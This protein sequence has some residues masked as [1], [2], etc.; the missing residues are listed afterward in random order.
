MRLGSGVQMQAGNGWRADAHGIRRAM[1][2]GC[3]IRAHCTNRCHSRAASTSVS[4]TQS[5]A[6]G[7]RVEVRAGVRRPGDERGAPRVWYVAVLLAGRRAKHVEHT[8]LQ[9]AQ[10]E[11]SSTASSYFL[12]CAI[13]QV[14]LFV[15]VRA[16]MQYI[17]QKS[18]S[19]A[20]TPMRQCCS[21]VLRYPA[22]ESASGH[23]HAHHWPARRGCRRAHS[24]ASR[25]KAFCVVRVRTR[26][27]AHAYCFLL[28]TTRENARGYWARGEKRRAGRSHWCVLCY[29]GT[30]VALY[31]QQR[32]ARTPRPHCERTPMRQAMRRVETGARKSS[33]WRGAAG[34]EQA[35][36]NRQRQSRVT[37]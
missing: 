37:W 7:A 32:T 11:G 1:Q 36:Q 33:E 5:R 13:L 27:I 29:R 26:H 23:A 34:A 21:A 14:L 16:L 20:M 12:A 6:Y 19:G 22:S 8:S 9:A 3:A 10:D 30:R 17:E 28:G 35:K 24:P 2:V 4:R 25:Q 15:R 31:A 18:S